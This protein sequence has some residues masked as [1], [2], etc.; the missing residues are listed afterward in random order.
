MARVKHAPA[1]RRRRK[2]ALKMAKGQYGARS[3]LHRTAKESVA[4]AMAYSYRDR[5]VKKRDI[6]SLWIIRINAACR[7]HDFSYSRFMDGLKKARVSVNR[8]MLAEM[9]VNDKAGFDRLIETSKSALV[10]K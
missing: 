6:R 3:R 1:S 4:R 9:A 10:K 5:R 2:K 8:K 7:L